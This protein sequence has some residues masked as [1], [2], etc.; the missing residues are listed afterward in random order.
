MARVATFLLIVAVTTVTTGSGGNQYADHPYKEYADATFTDGE[1]EGCPNIGWGPTTSKEAC[2]QSCRDKARCTGVNWSSTVPDCVQRA[3]PVPVPAPTGGALAGQYTAYAVEI[4]KDQCPVEEGIDFPGLDLN[5]ATGTTTDRKESAAECQAL[6]TA[7][8]KCN[9]FTWKAHSKECWKKSGIS[10]KDTQEGTTSGPACR[11]VAWSGQCVVDSSSRL[12]P[13]HLSELSP[14]TPSLCVSGCASKNYSYA[15]VQYAGECWC[16]GTTPPLSSLAP[17]SECS[18]NCNGDATKKCGGSW[19]M[20]VYAAVDTGVSKVKTSTDSHYY[21]NTDDNVFLKVCDSNSN[22]CDSSSL[23]NLDKND[24]EKAEVDEFSEFSMLGNCAVTSL[25][26]DITATLSKDGDDGWYPK[27]TQIVLN[28]GKE[29]I[30]YFNLWLDT[31]TGYSNSKTVPCQQIG[32]GEVRTKTDSQN[33]ANTNDNVFI[34][35]CDSGDNCCQSASLDN[36]DK[37]DFEKSAV[38]QFSESNMLGSCSNII[39]YGDITATLSKDGDDGWYPKWSQIILNNGTEFIC[40]FDLWLDS[41]TGYS[42]SKTVPC[43]VTGVA[44]VLTKT[45]SRTYANTNDN[46]FIK[47]CDSAENCCDSASLDNQDKNDFEKSEVDTFSASS[48]LGNCSNI[49]L[50]GD[51]TATL[52]KD[53][54]NGWYP[55]WT[56]IHLNNGKE[57]ICFFGL[58][59]DSDTGYSNSKTVTCEENGISEIRTKT[60]SRAYANTNDNVFIKVCDTPTNCC[61]SP[62][63][64]NEDKNDFEKSQVDTFT[65]AALMGSC[66]SINLHGRLMVTLS[67]DGDDGWYPEETEIVL[68]DGKHVTCKFGLWLDSETGYSNSKTVCQCEERAMTIPSE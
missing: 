11:Y 54:D 5:L 34:K 22:C 39:L 63:L 61:E 45:D 12:L 42:N 38:D 51:I 31:E 33:Y 23:D 15:G 20:N 59:L 28:D 57:Y 17:D 65:G 24:F 3:C 30:C 43:E 21:A 47:I 68:K 44:E 8:P 52:S 53:G 18:S 4:T 55:Q 62:S 41:D 10:R 2:I 27:W 19:R 49:N 9:F 67:K 7:D 37:D 25:E 36:T 6:C 29:Y 16:G 50:H 64:D 35:I 26:G 14:V 13:H 66:N 1:E 60:D 40:N 56:Q 32:V 58:W 48:M 46:V